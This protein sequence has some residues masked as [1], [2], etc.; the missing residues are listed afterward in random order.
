MPF[1]IDE[2]KEI[3]KEQQECIELVS[4][5]Q[6]KLITTTTGEINTIQSICDQIKFEASMGND[7]LELHPH[8]WMSN[9]ILSKTLVKLKELG[10]NIDHYEDEEFYLIS[11][12][13]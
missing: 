2:L 8:Q 12:D 9:A 4:A 7:S 13:I 1:T 5:E 6:A 10:Y 11:W 3:H